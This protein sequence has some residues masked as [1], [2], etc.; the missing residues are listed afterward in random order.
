MVHLRQLG[1]H[2]VCGV[3]AGACLG[4]GALLAQDETRAE[5]GSLRAKLA[6]AEEVLALSQRDFVAGA[7]DADHVFAAAEALAA[8]GRAEEALGYYVKALQLSPWNL[9]QQ[10]AYADML[11][12]KGRAEEAKEVAQVVAS[13]GE[14]DELV[15]RALKLMGKEPVA[16]P[17]VWEPSFQGRWIC[18]VRIGKVEDCVLNAAMDR[19]SRTL[20]LPA[21]E[22]EP[23]LGLPLPT[24]SA[25]NRWV[26]RTLIPAFPWRE[27][28]LQRVLESL[29]AASPQ[30][31]QP[32]RRLVLALATAMRREGVAEQA[33]GMEQMLKHFEKWDQQWKGSEMTTMLQDLRRATPLPGAV[34]VVGVTAADL[35]D[36]DSN[37]IFG[38]A[39]TGG[40]V[41]VTSYGRYTGPFNQAPPE[42]AK[43][44]GRLHKQ[45]L[46]GVGYALGVPR[47][48]D[49]TSARA[50]P[51][52]LQEHDAKSEYMSA[53]CR[54]GFESAL[55][56]SLPAEAL[57]PDQRPAAAAR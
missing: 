44:L 41:A 24:R 6:A 27:A 39:L 22:L 5:S 25:L 12:K 47:P 36:G 15:N 9:E 18:F 56:I 37:Y 31:V 3:L 28:P 33:A 46:S 48:T 40:R 11:Q 16:P 26:E 50:Y 43:L 14:T 35:Y 29:G 45:L 55:D 4:A 20:G 23:G 53:A 13:R 7:K 51:A 21:Y 57:P 49:P 10:M 30:E 19:L 34:A 52:S 42:R 8:A 32:P 54:A 1:F 2:W 38:T 17:P